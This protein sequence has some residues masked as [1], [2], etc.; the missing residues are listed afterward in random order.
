MAERK[1]NDDILRAIDTFSLSFLC[2]ANWTLRIFNCYSAV[3]VFPFVY[4]WTISKH[5]WSALTFGGIFR[6]FNKSLYFTHVIQLNRRHKKRMIS[7]EFISNL[8]N[9]A[10][11]EKTSKNWENSINTLFICTIFICCRQKCSRQ[12]KCFENRSD[13][14]PYAIKS[15]YDPSCCILLFFHS[16]W[17]QKCQN[18]KKV[19]MNRMFVQTNRITFWP[20]NFFPRKTFKFV[21]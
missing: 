5:I 3:H 1:K 14:T 20:I 6:F 4:W 13:R 12:N 9:N 10:I 7:I 21:K 8:Y 18:H 15:F 19:K 16:G 11:K 17:E 2:F